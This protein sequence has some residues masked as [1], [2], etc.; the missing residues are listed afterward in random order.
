MGNTNEEKASKKELG[1]SEMGPYTLFSVTHETRESRSKRIR[2]LFEKQ[3]VLGFLV[4]VFDFEWTIRRAIVMM[5][6][7]PAMVIKA[8]FDNKDYSG[9]RHYQDCWRVCV[10]QTR[11]DDI[12]T[13]ARVVCGG[14]LEEDASEEDKKAIQ[15]AMDLRSRLVHGLS[16]N[17]PRSQTDTAFELLMCATE[18]IVNFVEERSGKSMFERLYK[19]RARC[20]TCRRRCEFKQER[21]DAKKRANEKHAGKRRKSESK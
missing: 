8:R 13:L 19:P 14:L 1:Q 18:R 10:K 4:A 17:L 20:N 11:D 12:P 21:L 7:C 16:G 15:A 3:P 5:S 6:G 9:W 2:T